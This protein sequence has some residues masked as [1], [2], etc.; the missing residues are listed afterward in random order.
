MADADRT[1]SRCAGSELCF[2]AAHRR[3]AYFPGTTW[4]PIEGSQ[5]ELAVMSLT[6]R[7][8][9]RA[10][11]LQQR[12]GEGSFRSPGAEPGDRGGHLED[13]VC[14][15]TGPSLQDSPNDPCLLVFTLSCSPLP[16][17][18]GVGLHDCYGLNGVS[19]KFIF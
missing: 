11:S 14:L 15:C 12:V 2:Q 7:S 1:W 5:P 13:G 17:H 19:P 6:K 18:I 8:L 4:G 9:G 10:E 3:H 16:Y